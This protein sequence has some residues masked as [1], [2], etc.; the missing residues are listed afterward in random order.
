MPRPT[1]TR[2]VG[3]TPRTTYF[4][5]AGTPMGVL[6]EV[7]LGHD[8]VEAIRLKN[9]VGLSQD[10]TANLSSPSSFG[11]SK[12]DRRRGQWKG[13]TDRGR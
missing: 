9:L 1:C 12:I 4:K 6:E 13:L 5:P 3:F 2:R 7:L 11:S 10:F 8:E